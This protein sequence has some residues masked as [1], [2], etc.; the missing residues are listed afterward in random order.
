MDRAGRVSDRSI[1][2]A[3]LDVYELAA[4]LERPRRNAF[5]EMRARPALLVR[6]LDA[7]GAEGWGEAF[8]NWPAFGAAHRARIL[9]EILSP[10]L[11][12]RTFDEPET[13]WQD[14]TERTRPLVLQC[15]E[16]GPFAQCIAA[17]DM[18]AWGLVCHR[19]GR[20]LADYWGTTP[21]AVPIYASALTADGL[22]DRVPS[23][24]ADGWTG[25]K[26]KVGFGYDADVAALRRLRHLVGPGVAIM[27]DA[28]QA[29]NV[30]D[31]LRHADAF[32]PHDVAWLEEP[33]PADAPVTAWAD[34]VRRSPIPVA[35]GENV[36]GDD[37]FEQLLAVGLHV[38]QPDAAKWGGL[39]GLR[40]VAAMASR[41][42]ASFAPHFLGAAV[43]LVATTAAA[44]ALAASWIEVDA[45]P[46]LLQSDLLDISVSA[47]WSEEADTRIAIKFEP[48]AMSRY[49]ASGL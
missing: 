14:L 8:C 13:L 30:D 43:G 24:R 19:S 7:D 29:W 33:I 32:A 28:N 12:G 2:P 44:R 34:L 48:D 16:P 6:L 36:R 46:N 41:A 26:L 37:A 27:V 40:R 35:A 22:D 15:D 18:A 25:F 38:V 10:L 20:G 1:T 45:T 49:A 39:S 4:P 42:G 23:L 21:T 31:A 11:V 3:C 17:L 9:R 47:R 5:G